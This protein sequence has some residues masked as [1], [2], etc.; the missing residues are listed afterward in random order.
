M[1]KDEF[2]MYVAQWLQDDYL[3]PKD[4]EVLK[5]VLRGVY[6]LPDNLFI[7]TESD[8]CYWNDKEG[9]CLMGKKYCPDNYSCQYFD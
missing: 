6:A 5:I 1:T 8:C 9:Y 3:D 2:G 7:P 4:R